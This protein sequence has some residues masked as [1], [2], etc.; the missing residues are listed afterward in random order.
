MVGSANLAGHRSNAANADDIAGLIGPDR[1]RISEFR[2][3]K[4]DC[5]S[6]ETWIRYLARLGYP[7]TSL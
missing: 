7:S 6:L 5:F 3:G 4:L 1:P 2:R